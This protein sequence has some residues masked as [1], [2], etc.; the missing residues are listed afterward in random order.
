MARR[1]PRCSFCKR[2]WPV[3]RDEEFAR[4]ARL[5]FIDLDSITMARL[6]R[7]E[8]STGPLQLNAPPDV[9]GLCCPR[10]LV[11]NSNR[12][13]RFVRDE[14]DRR[15]HWSTYEAQGG[16]F[17]GWVCMSCE[18]ELDVSVR[19]LIPQELPPCP[20]GFDHRRAFAVCFKS[21]FEGWVCVTSNLD[22]QVPSLLPCEWQSA[23]LKNDDDIA[24]DDIAEGDVA[25][26]DAKTI[27]DAIT[28]SSS[29]DEMANEM[30]N[31]LALLARIA[32]NA[33]VFDELRE[34][35]V[36]MQHSQASHAQ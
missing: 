19:G 35:D 7:E 13:V 16:F 17:E 3:E 26:D 36:L 24:D 1:H 2:P 4:L 20:H 32:A 12:G 34:L 15:M 27:V 21:S 30:A 33:E 18:Q 25:E 22:G 6:P 9:V 10:M 11:I 29:G 5:S 14:N 31:D 28:I 23:E 8:D